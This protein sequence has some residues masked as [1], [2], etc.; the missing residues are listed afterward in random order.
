MQKEVLFNGNA[1]S[2]QLDVHERGLYSFEE[3][4]DLAAGLLV[5]I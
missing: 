1:R 5:L 2:R 3:N 4:T